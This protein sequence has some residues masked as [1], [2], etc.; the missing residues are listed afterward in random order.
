[1]FKV[2]YIAV[3]CH[4]IFISGR[5]RSRYSGDAFVYTVKTGKHDDD[6]P[7]N[8]KQHDTDK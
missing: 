2:S 7:G 8:K 6:E 3:K 5:R 4:T 1:M